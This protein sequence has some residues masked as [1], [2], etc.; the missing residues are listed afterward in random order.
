MLRRS[1]QI[2]VAVALLALGLVV[3]FAVLRLRGPAD[4]LAEARAAFDRHDYARAITVLDFAERG[5]GV[6]NDRT[7]RERLWR[8]R[9]A[10][11][12]ELGN[13][14]GALLDV[15]H[16]IDD[17]HDDEPLQ[18]DRIRLSAQSDKADAALQLARDFLAKNPGHGRGLELAGEAAELALQPRIEDLTEVIER[19][20]GSQHRERVRRDWRSYLYRADGDLLVAMSIQDLSDL[21]AAEPGL[22]ARWPLV[23][24]DLRDL[25]F[26]I[27]ESLSFFQ[28]SLE[29]GGEPVAAFRGLARAYDFAGRR[30]DLLILCDSYRQRFDHQYLEEAG[31]K[32]AWSLVRAGLDRAALAT[33]DRWLPR[34]RLEQRAAAIDLGAATP[35][36]LLARV[37]AANHIGDRQAL[38]VAL[39]DTQTMRQ[40]LPTHPTGFLCAHLNTAYLQ[41]RNG[42]HRNAAANLDGAIVHILRG[43]TP[44]DA[45]DLLAECSQQRVAEQAAAGASVDERLST[46]KGWLEERGSEVAPRLALA[47]FQLDNGR[48]AAAVTVLGEAAELEPD[49]EQVFAL[50]VAAAR[51][52]YRDTNQDGL[53][54]VEQCKQRMILAPEV[55]DP[56]AYVLCAETALELG[57]LPVAGESARMAVDAFPHVQ[58]PRLLEARINLRAGRTNDA[59]RS[60]AH[61]LESGKT[62]ETAALL[63][64]EAALAADGDVASAVGQAMRLSRPEPGLLAQQLRLTL[65]LAP[66]AATPYLPRVVDEPKAAAELCILAAHAAARLGR[67]ADT[68]ALFAR[69]VPQAG[70]LPP[71]LRAD[72]A[73]ALGAWFEAAGAARDDATL[74]PQ[75]TTLLA[76][77]Q[78]QDAA[79]A[80]PLLAAARVLETT[81]PRTANVAIT[82][83]LAV[84][85]PEARSG[86]AYL[87]AGRLAATLGELRLAE[88]HWTAALAFD[89]QRPAAALALVRLCLLQERTERGMQLLRLIDD[90]DAAMALRVGGLPLADIKATAAVAADQ[91]DLLAQATLAMLGKPT[92]LDWRL[93]S[94]PTEQSNRCDLLSVLASPE[95][96]GHARTRMTALA[97]DGTRTSQLLLARTLAAAGDGRGAARIHQALFQRGMHDIVFWREVALAAKAPGYDLPPRFVLAMTEEVTSGT[98]QPSAVALGFALDSMA[99][100]F[101]RAG[102]TDTADQLRFGR[103]TL[104]PTRSDLGQAEFAKL[105]AAPDTVRA[106]TVLDQVLPTCRSADRLAIVEHLAQLA[107]RL[108]AADA[109]SAPDLAI[110][111]RRDLDQAGPYG[112]LLHFLIEFA[113]AGSPAHLG[114]ADE[115]QLLLGQLALTGADRDDPAWTARSVARLVHRNGIPKTVAALEQVLARF[116][117]GRSLWQARAELLAQIDRGDE[118]LADLRLVLAHGALPTDRLACVTLA[119]IDFANTDA[120]NAQLQQLPP[121][122]LATPAGAFARGMMALRRGDPDGAL[123][124]LNQAPVRDDGLHLLVKAEAY[125]QYHDR[126]GV[127]RAQALFEELQRDYPSSELARNAGS[128]A[129]QLSPH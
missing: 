93:T 121:E 26:K 95:L 78:V 54:L 3:G 34:G 15:E 41:A 65:A 97:A 72:L 40:A 109:K 87:R 39:A 98:L 16:L 112:A 81:H 20:H 62:S 36:M 4:A 114:E 92:P 59:V 71:A 11:Y 58:M 86:E 56:L 90:A 17:G 57:L 116:P 48:S 85:D 47:Q 22:A 31:A 126:D 49:N 70:A 75:A 100:A 107:R 129:R 104:L 80:P 113:P 77:L 122:M 73:I 120:D 127:A 64:L 14:N 29:A 10:A 12:T 63:A 83:A 69:L 30:D 91:G 82:Q 21:Y 52:L 118:G 96:A 35:S 44:R 27:Q 25:R 128:F 79:A 24:R 19:E 66:S 18:L 45:P 23:L 1:L 117:L 94:D 55:E 13:P 60:L 7:L 110:A 103:W 9:Y 8:L 43:A 50:R 2:F 115:Q 33:V 105:V 119:A 68:E 32:A 28:Q 124:L 111:I 88:E 46:L 89:D 106:W 108:I 76:N 6:R 99:A 84:A 38:Q 37:V 51:D 102:K 125:L 61:L 101:D 123:V 53:R 67:L 5:A 74:E 42:D